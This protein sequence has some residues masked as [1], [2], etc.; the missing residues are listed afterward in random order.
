[1][2]QIYGSKVSFYLQGNKL[3]DQLTK[4]SPDRVKLIHPKTQGLPRFLILNH[5]LEIILGDITN[6]SI[7][8][9]QRQH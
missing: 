8:C 4:A 3:A 1:M 6:I 7:N 9:Y 5:K 2:Q